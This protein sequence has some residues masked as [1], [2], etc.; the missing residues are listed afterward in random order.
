MVFFFIQ[1]AL[2]FC[3]ENTKRCV[4]RPH[5]RTHV[6]PPFTP[7]M[8]VLFFRQN[9]SLR[10]PLP[11]VFSLRTFLHT[12]NLSRHFKASFKFRIIFVLW[13]FYYV[14]FFFLQYYFPIPFPVQSKPPCLSPCA[15][16]LV[17]FPLKTVIKCVFY[18]SD[19]FDQVLFQF[20]LCE[21]QQ[22]FQ[23]FFQYSDPNNN[24]SG[25]ERLSKK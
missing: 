8:K 17:L 2:S 19:M 3:T 1:G 5:A 16:Y 12:C 15:S 21:D 6:R 18:F 11:P 9:F 25:F 7:M 14:S 24:E 20:I 13:V 22:L 10:F 4:A 23:I